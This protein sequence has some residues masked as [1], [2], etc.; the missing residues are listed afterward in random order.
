MFLLY[1]KQRR[2]IA[3]RPYSSLGGSEI[4]YIRA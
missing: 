3:D 4:D 1:Q 2:A